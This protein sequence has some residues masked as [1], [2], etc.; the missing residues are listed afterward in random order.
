MKDKPG[1]ILQSNPDKHV[2]KVSGRVIILTDI[3][4]IEGNIHNYPSLRLSDL[5]NSPDK[6]IPV[7]NAVIYDLDGEQELYQAD[8]I[9]L[10]K[11]IIR[12]VMETKRRPF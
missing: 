9:S 4:K 7:T 12:I 3:N 8:F 11:S 10:N 5:L 1:K 2:D 6:F